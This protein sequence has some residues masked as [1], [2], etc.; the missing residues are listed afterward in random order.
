[1]VF[2]RPTSSIFGAV[3]LAAAIL[4]APWQAL[5]PAGLLLAFAGLAGVT[6]YAYRAL[7][8]TPPSSWLTTGALPLICP[9]TIGPDVPFL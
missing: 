5:W 3:L 8:G 9:L 1:M 2:T 7:A 4:S 6:L